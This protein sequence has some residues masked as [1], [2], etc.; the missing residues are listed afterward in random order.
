[1]DN[2]MPYLE[3]KRREREA[4]MERPRPEAV[5]ESCACPK[6]TRSMTMKVALDLVHLVTCPHCLY[7]F[8]L[9]V[10]SGRGAA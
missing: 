9:V 4:H 6:C 7:R 5:R 8:E 3:D 2:V 1:M 10:E